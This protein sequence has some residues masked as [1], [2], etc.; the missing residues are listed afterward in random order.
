VM[1]VWTQFYEIVHCRMAP[2]D[3]KKRILLRH[4]NPD[5]GNALPDVGDYLAITSLIT[6]W[7][8]NDQWVTVASRRRK[9]V[10]FGSQD[11]REDDSNASHTTPNHSTHMSKHV[12]DGTLLHSNLTRA[13]NNLI[14]ESDDETGTTTSEYSFYSGSYPSDEEQ[15]EE[16]P[17]IVCNSY[18]YDEATGAFVSAALRDTG[19]DFLYRKKED[20]SDLWIWEMHPSYTRPPVHN[21][22]NHHTPTLKESL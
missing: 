15:T 22:V 13:R 20:D 12:F 16:A 10:I 9:R 4:F 6:K 5:S 3:I 7:I 18:L 19:S 11:H 1:V 21:H 14:V 2:D 17:E 8:I